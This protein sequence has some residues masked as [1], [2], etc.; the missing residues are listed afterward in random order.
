MRIGIESHYVH[1]IA[2]GTRTY[3]ENITRIMPALA[4]EHDFYLYSHGY[5]KTKQVRHNVT[6]VP[7][8]YRL[9]HLN[10]LVGF[11]QVARRNKLSLF[12][13]QYVGG[14]GIKIPQVVTVHDVFQASHPQYFPFL[15]RKQL[16]LMMRLVASRAAAV[17]TVSS[18]SKAAI[19]HFYNIS[20]HRVTV[21][22]EAA[23]DFFTPTKSDGALRR[24]M[25]AL[26]IGNG[27][28][29]LFVGRLVPIKNLKGLICSYGLFRDRVKV[30]VQLV[31][32]GDKDDLFGDDGSREAYLT[33]RYKASIIFTGSV[34]TTLLRALYSGAEAL[35]LPSFCEGFG[36]PAIEAMACG[37][38]CIVSDRGALPEVVGD[39]GTIVD[40]DEPDEL[41]NAMQDHI[42]RED[43]KP[44]KREAALQRAAMFSWEH[45][46]RQ[47]L[48]VYRNVME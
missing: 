37:T 48:Q 6:E 21:A 23:S 2:R 16:D 4:P 45:C 33:C 31:I 25:N 34:R 38:P 3:L 7:S 18:Y 30:P 27:P 17:V 24:Q 15:H 10:Y 20:A 36:L 12:H 14:M 5:E 35:V 9:N 46:A 47:T 13:S 41:A 42:E 40:I 26:G 28:F 43:L 19:C 32:V 1:G 39:A 29:F 11:G 22:Y 8:P 44:A